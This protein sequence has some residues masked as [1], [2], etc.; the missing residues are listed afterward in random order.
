MVH[1]KISKLKMKPKASYK[2]LKMPSLKETENNCFY[3]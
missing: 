3:Q 2:S 1:E